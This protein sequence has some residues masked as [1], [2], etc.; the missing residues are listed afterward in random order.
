MNVYKTVAVRR[1]THDAGGNVTATD[2]ELA[3]RI[4]RWRGGGALTRATCRAGLALEWV[5]IASDLNPILLTTKK[6]AETF[7]A[8]ADPIKTAN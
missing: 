2:G 6:G 3:G 5:V 8:F 7:G 1:N 4:E